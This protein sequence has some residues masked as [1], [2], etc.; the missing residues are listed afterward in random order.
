MSRVMHANILIVGQGLAGTLL[1]WELERA[2]LAFEIADAGHGRAA[3]R[4]AAGIINPITGRR[5]VKSWRVDTLLPLARE[6]YRAMEKELGVPLWREMRVRRLYLDEDERRVL[7]EK[8]ARGDFVEYVGA[9]DEEGFWIE[10]AARVDPA[11]LVSA[12]RARWVATGVLREERVE[13]GRARMEYELVIDCT[14]ALRP[15]GGNVDAFGFVP[16][17]YSKGECLT[18]EVG[19][20]ARDVVLNRRHWILPEAEGRAMVGATHVPGRKDV[21]LTAE[22]RAEL[23]ASVAAMNAGAFKV[24]GHA[25]GVRSYLADKKPVAGRHPGDRGFGVLN[26]LG[27][28]GALFGPTLARQWARHLVDGAPFESE[29]DVARLWRAPRAQAAV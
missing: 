2:G 23:E 8:Q 29:V 15:E 13:F 21:E 14:G 24:T 6:T 22:A 1:A 28:K 20:L 25:A 4:V 11:A 17:Q 5:I 3:S 12:A 19:G 16:W 26:G 10:G 18:I 27:S 9:A 7:T